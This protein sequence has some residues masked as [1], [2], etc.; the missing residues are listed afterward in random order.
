M[1]HAQYMLMLM[2]NIK[3]YRLMGEK[4]IYGE[5]FSIRFNLILIFRKI[6]KNTKFTKK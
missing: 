1:D 3:I 4:F 5:L 6:H 2:V